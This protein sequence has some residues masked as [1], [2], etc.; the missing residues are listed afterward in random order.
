MKRRK[1]TKL[2]NES[3]FQNNIQSDLSICNNELCD[4]F[5][6]KYQN[7]INIKHYVKKFIFIFYFFFFEILQSFKI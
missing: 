7:E 5:R 4:F 6:I 2:T 3:F 1:I